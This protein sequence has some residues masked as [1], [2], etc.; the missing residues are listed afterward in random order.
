MHILEETL[1]ETIAHP[2]L[3][4]MFAARKRVFVDLLKWDIPVLAGQYEID[5]FD[6]PDA[7][8]LV[9]LDDQGAHLAS[10]RLLRS[11]GPHILAD[12]FPSLCAD[13]VPRGRSIREIT[14]FCIDPELTRSER[15]L[16]RDQLVSALVSHA[17]GDGVASYTAVA[18]VPWFEQ[19]ARFGWQCEALGPSRRLCGEALVGL[20]IMID[21]TTP[22]ALARTGMLRP[23]D[24]LVQSAMET[25]S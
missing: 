13:A 1:P 8:Y 4:A 12:L 22:G 11:D 20:R 15:R 23:A 18:S 24:Y 17:L 16:A 7:T 25:R 6:T 5:Q 2:A 21:E 9:L 14:R 3:R 10:T 19:I